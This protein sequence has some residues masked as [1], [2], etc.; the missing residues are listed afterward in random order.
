M[1]ERIGFCVVGVH[2][3]VEAFKSFASCAFKQE[4]KTFVAHS[5]K[6]VEM[7]LWQFHLPLMLRGNN[8][9]NNETKREKKLPPC[10]FTAK[11]KGVNIAHDK[12][13]AIA[14]VQNVHTPNVLS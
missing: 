10:T 7:S 1:S 3:S 14:G 6:A 5:F 4:Y 12:F 8:S 11:T 2:F 9:N 13:F